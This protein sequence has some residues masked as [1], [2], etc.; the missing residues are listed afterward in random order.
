[1]TS[2]EAPL[3][4]TITEAFAFVLDVE[5]GP[6]DDFF[7]LGGDSLNSMVVLAEL[8]EQLGINLTPTAVLS[9]PTAAQLADAIERGLVVEG[10]ATEPVPEATGAERAPAAWNQRAELRIAPEAA[11]RGFLSWVYQFNGR[12]NVE[13]VGRAVDEVLQ[14]HDVLR[15]TFEYRGHRVEQ[16]ITPFSPGS[17]RIVDIGG[18]SKQ[19]ALAIALKAIDDWYGEMSVAEDPRFRSV[20]YTIDA[21]TNVFA[22]F[23][24][25]ALVD[26]ESGALLTAELS[27][28]YARHA[29]QPEPELPA[30]V[31]VRYL[32]Y[33]LANPVPLPVLRA[34]RN[35]WAHYAHTVP[36]EF[37]WPTE[38]RPTAATVSYHLSPAEWKEIVGGAQALRTTPYLFLLGCLQAAVHRVTG[39]EHLPLTSAVIDRSDPLTERMIGNFTS[40]VRIEG[41]VGREERFADVMN[42]TVDALRTAVAASVLPAPLAEARMPASVP[43]RP[44]HSGVEFYMFQER[45]ALVFPGVRRRRFRLNGGLEPLRLNCTQRMDGRERFSF[46]STTATEDE[47][48]RLAAVFRALV[49]EVV[50][51]PEQLVGTIAVDRPMPIRESGVRRAGTTELDDIDTSGPEPAVVGTVDPRLHWS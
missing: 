39:A 46:T 16:V 17:M 24:A 43:K 7:G 36:F 40:V 2:L 4:D 25:E 5:V 42:H 30:P 1:M 10:G 23:V 47:L 45:E 6:D 8:Q 15:T 48:V 31:D 38:E 14:R 3:V 13:A 33:V 21:K 28:A 18:H 32:D 9:Y 22:A 41:R 44:P 29:D 12:L 51:D 49:D 35:H 50:R 34:A 27:R 19:E 11:S 37:G 20:L 26:G